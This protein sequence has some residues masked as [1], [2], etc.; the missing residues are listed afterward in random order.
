[1]LQSMGL[2]RVGHD[3]ATEEQQMIGKALYEFQV[4]NMI[5][6]CHQFVLFDCTVLIFFFF[7]ALHNNW[8]LEKDVV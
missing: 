4:Y 7:F 3:L 1:M 8:V 2:Q 5:C 6:N